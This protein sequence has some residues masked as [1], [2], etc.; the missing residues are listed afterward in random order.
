MTACILIVE[1]NPDNLKLM[2]WVLEDEGYNVKSVNS[3]EQALEYVEKHEFQLIL[4]DID[5]P[6]MN[7]EEATRLMRKK[8]SLAHLPIVAVTAH[9]LHDKVREIMNSGFTDIAVKPIN[10]SLLVEMIR[11]ILKQ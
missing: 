10:E 6:V 7:G 3:A 5:L 1:D 2:T 4:M 11:R 8:E 9:A